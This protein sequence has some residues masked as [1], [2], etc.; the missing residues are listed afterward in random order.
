MQRGV[1]E[2]I[3]ISQDLFDVIPRGSLDPGVAEDVLRIV[4]SEETRM[5]VASVKNYRRK[6]EQERYGWI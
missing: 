5:K 3:G 2:I 1:V 6:D 4:N